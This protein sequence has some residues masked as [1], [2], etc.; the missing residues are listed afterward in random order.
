MLMAT[1]TRS[2]MTRAIGREKRRGERKRGSRRVLTRLEFFFRYVLAPYYFFS[3]RTRV[4]RFVC[5]FHSFFLFYFLFRSSTMAGARDASTQAL[6]TTSFIKGVLGPKWQQQQE[7]Q[8]L[9]TQCVLSPR[10]VFFL[11]FLFYSANIYVGIDYYAYG[12]HHQITNDEGDRERK[13]TRREQTGLKTRQ[14]MSRVLFQI[15][16]CPL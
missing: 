6:P 2:Q 13:E 12:H 14:N 8:G 11:G 5:V 1:T 7:W 3:P 4:R 10:Y 9:E 16:S 15:S